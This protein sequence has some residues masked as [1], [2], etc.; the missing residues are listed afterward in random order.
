VRIFWLLSNPQAGGPPLFCRLH[1]GCIVTQIHLHE[2]CRS[3]SF[4]FFKH[5]HSNATR[6]ASTSLSLAKLLYTSFRLSVIQNECKNNSF[7]IFQPHK[8]GIRCSETSIT[9]Y[10]LTLR[11]FVEARKPQLHGCE[12]LK[13]RNIKKKF[14]VVTLLGHTA[15]ILIA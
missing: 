9:N 12:S 7:R 11:N 13:C 1:R 15:H 10:Q 3:M 2:V 14:R 4:I 8:G 6:T 5:S